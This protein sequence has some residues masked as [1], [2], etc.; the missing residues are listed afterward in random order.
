MAARSR[1]LALAVAVLGMVTAII[2]AP[3]RPADYRSAA[4]AA[5]ARY[6]RQ[7]NALPPITSAAELRRQLV[8]VPRLFGTMVGRIAALRA[9]RA[10]GSQAA[11]LVASLTQVHGVLGR[12]RDAFLRGDSAGVDAA[13]RS[14]TRLSREAARS[15]KALGLTACARLAAD[16]AK[17]PQP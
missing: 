9:P 14:G 7:T 5:C 6:D 15:A 8:L 16:A 12:M 10:Q 4:D 13:Q 17:G 3:A 11:R 1:R 2:A